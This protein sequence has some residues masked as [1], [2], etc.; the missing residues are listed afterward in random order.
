MLSIKKRIHQQEVREI[1][2]VDVSGSN[3]FDSD[4]R[5]QGNPR[6]AGAKRRPT[7]PKAV[8]K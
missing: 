4:Y 6:P 5:P 2:M 3:L 7:N 8:H 1:Y